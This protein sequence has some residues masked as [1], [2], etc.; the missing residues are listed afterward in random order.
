MREEEQED[1]QQHPRNQNKPMLLLLL[2]L[3]MMMMMMM[4]MGTGM[5]LMMML[6]VI[7]RGGIEDGMGMT[8]MIRMRRGRAEAYLKKRN[9]AKSSNTSWSNSQPRNIK[10]RAEL[11]VQSRQGIISSAE[12]DGNRP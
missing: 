1:K 3:L 4:R 9:I 7:W 5:L 6:I 11:S 2:L 8:I 10:L 12:V